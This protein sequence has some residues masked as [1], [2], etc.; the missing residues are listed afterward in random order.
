M[1]L[2]K[3]V[4]GKSMESPMVTLVVISMSG[5]SQA[6]LLLLASLLEARHHVVW[7][8]SLQST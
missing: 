8:M 2:P 4:V 5:R 1:L 6:P 3:R 7:R